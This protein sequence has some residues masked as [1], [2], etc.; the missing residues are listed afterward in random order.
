LFLYSQ[1]HAP[2][3]KF[4]LVYSSFLNHSGGLLLCLAVAELTVTKMYN[5]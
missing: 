5:S 2:D 3:W 1:T 4:N